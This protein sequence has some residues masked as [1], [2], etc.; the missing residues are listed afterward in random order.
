MVEYSWEVLSLFTSPSENGLND[1]VKRAT[2]RYQAKEGSY[3]ADVYKDT[4]FDSPNPDDY[5]NF[6]SLSQETVINWVKQKI[7]LQELKDEVDQKLFDTKNPSRVLEKQKPWDPNHLYSFED[8]YVLFHNGN[9]IAGPDMWNSNLFNYALK[10][11][12]LE[13]SFPD[14]IQ[15]R[16]KK[17]LPTDQP[18]VVDSET[19]T[20]LYK[21]TIL[22]NQPETSIFDKNDYLIWNLNVW[23]VTGTYQIQEKP[24]DEVKNNLLNYVNRLFLEKIFSHKLTTQIDNFEYQLPLS[25]DFTNMLLQN[26][27]YLN[28]NENAII[29]FSS[30]KF[31]SLTKTQ[32]KNILDLV[33]GKTNQLRA[34]KENFVNQ[35]NNASS[36]NDLKLINLSIVFE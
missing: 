5:L 22:N 14:N 4:F 19:N 6:N 8:T 12:N 33:V 7:N 32:I 36:V 31:L 21:C 11:V 30:N 27:S 26:L 17:I 23:P 29:E 28:D 15:V 2:W 10:K 20:I 35:I 1:V 24:L 9:L 34:Q 16:Q 3:A 13:E 25:F 18:L